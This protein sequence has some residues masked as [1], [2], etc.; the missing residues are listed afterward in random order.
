MD[1]WQQ[2]RN[3]GCHRRRNPPPPTDIMWPTAIVISTIKTKAKV[4]TPVLH[5]RPILYGPTSVARN[6]TDAIKHTYSKDIPRT[7]FSCSYSSSY[8]SAFP[9]LHISFLTTI[10]LSYSLPTSTLYPPVSA[11]LL[12]L[13]LP[14]LLLLF[15]T[16]LLPDVFVLMSVLT[17]LKLTSSLF[18]VLP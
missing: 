15:T 17:V 1:W 11:A 10:I 2:F 5:R 4:L 14:L 16:V 13:L 9:A 7:S 3:I 8:F 18:T 12:S 6:A